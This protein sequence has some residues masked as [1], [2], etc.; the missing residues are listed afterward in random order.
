MTI[1]IVT[2]IFVFGT[3][4]FRQTE[5]GRIGKQANTFARFKR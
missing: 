1:N 4:R 3:D 2:S 5:N